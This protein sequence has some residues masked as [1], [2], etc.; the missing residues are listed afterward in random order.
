MKSL[1]IWLLLL[2]SAAGV[3]YH[4][5]NQSLPAGELV[6]PSAPQIRDGGDALH[7]L[8]RIRAQIGL[9]ALAHAPVLE[10]SARRHARYLTLNPE[11]GHGEHHPDNPH[12][13]AQKLT[14]RTRLAGYLYNGVHEN[15]STEEEAAESSDSDIRTQQRQVDGLM[16]AIYHRLSLLDRHTDE[17]GAAFVRENGK[18]VVV[19]NQSNSRFERH[20]AQGRNQPEA[21][22]HYYRNACHNGAVVYTDEVMPAQELLYTAYP[23]GSGAL[24]YFYGERPDPVPGYEMTGNPAS[25]DF[26]EAAGK[27]AMKSFK[28]YRG[29]NE[30]RPVKILTAGNDPNGRLTAYQFALFPLKPLEY[31]TLY[32]AVF[33]YVRNGRRAQAKWQFKTRKPDYPYFEVNGGETLAVRKG[34]KYFIHWRGRWCL[35][36]CT[37][38]TYRQRLGSRLS[39][40]RHE[41]G[42]IVFSV[43]GM[44]GSRITLAPEDS[45]GRGVTLYLQD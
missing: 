10:N 33:D 6:Y 37:R 43:G 14:E 13:T 5:Q 26:S 15:I 34:E 40:G 29:K 41:A 27:I 1:F 8:N 11:D 9:H 18:T 36:A 30:I 25:I 19:F 7:Y 35:D 17:A 4:T 20:C 39:I 38:Y 28:L 31:G 23:V 12:Y 42:G 22:R 3:F 24:P 44:T 2:G 32:T 21:G 45:P 16:S